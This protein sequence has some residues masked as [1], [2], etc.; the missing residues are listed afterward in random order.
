MLA[1]IA[2]LAFGERNFRVIY[3]DLAEVIAGLPTTAGWSSRSDIDAARLVAIPGFWSQGA[4]A[5]AARAAWDAPVSKRRF[6]RRRWG[7]GLP[8]PIAAR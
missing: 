1:Y 3:N 4:P 2:R 5:G 6:Q 8:H 7:A